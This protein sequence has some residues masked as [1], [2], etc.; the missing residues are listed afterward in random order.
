MVF[1]EW[2]SNHPTSF[3]M[4]PEAAKLCLPALGTYL[5]HHHK[6]GFVRSAP[7]TQNALHPCPHALSLSVKTYFIFKANIKSHLLGGI[8]LSSLLDESLLFFLNLHSTELNLSY[9]LLC[10]NFAYPYPITFLLHLFIN[11]VKSL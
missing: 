2:S 1:T 4:P 9:L 5:V 7:F 6:S 11:S 8:S 10:Y 3:Q